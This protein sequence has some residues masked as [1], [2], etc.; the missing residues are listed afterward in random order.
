MY[1]N[2]ADAHF[3]YAF[4]EIVEFIQLRLFHSLQKNISS[5]KLLWAETTRQLGIIG[6]TNVSALGFYYKWNTLCIYFENN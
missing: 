4:T 5:Q 2:T 1:G 6:G 3:A